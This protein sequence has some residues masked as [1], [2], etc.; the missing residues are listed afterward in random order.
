MTFP[1][2]DDHCIDFFA[3]A[4][5]DGLMTFPPGAR[6]LEIGSAEGDW[7]RPMLSIRPDLHIV[8]IDVRSTKHEHHITGDVLT[9]DFEPT[10]FDAVVAISSLEHVGLGG[11]GDPLDPDGDRHAA[12]RA[13]TWLKPGGL[14]YFDVPFGDT[15]QLH[16]KWRRYDRDALRARLYPEEPCVMVDATELRVTHP[17]SPYLRVILRKHEH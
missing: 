13:W 17:D 16:G 10:S 12:T 15:Y 6:V 14:F 8:G 3:Q 4:W 11:Y 7:Q 2:I 9:H 5:N 1:K